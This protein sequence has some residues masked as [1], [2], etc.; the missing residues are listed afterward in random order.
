MHC[1]TIPYLKI[2]PNYNLSYYIG[3][4]YP[5]SI[6][7][8]TIPYLKTLTSLKISRRPYK[9]DHLKLREPIRIECY[10]TR[11]VR[12]SESSI[13]STQSSLEDAYW[14]SAPLGS[15][16]AIAYFDT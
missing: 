1:R 16:L 9:F 3:E 11:V 10:V 2:L 13:T 8:R 6:H 4:Q 5:D 14:L 7:S 15:R 12:Q